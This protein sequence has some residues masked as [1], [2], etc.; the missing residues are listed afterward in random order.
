MIRPPPISTR[1]D[2]HFPYTTLFRSTQALLRVDKLS[3]AYTRKRGF[4]SRAAPPVEIVKDVSF[5]LF[6]GETLALLGESGCGKTTT[7]KALLRLLDKQAA[8]DGQAT[9]GGENLLTARGA[10]LRRLRQ[11]IQIVFQDP[12]RKS[13][14]L[15]S[16]H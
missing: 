11:E 6:P 5:E 9:L 15:N 4:L 1:T 12:D 3:V 8:V 10:A 7:A 14:R 2:S 16:S 13:T